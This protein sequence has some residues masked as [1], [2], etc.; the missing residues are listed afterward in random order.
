MLYTEG[1]AEGTP[2]HTRPPEGGAPLVLY[3]GNCAFCSAQAERLGRL[4]GGR[5]VLRPLQQEG[6]LETFPGLS[7]DEAM[8]EMK[9]IDGCG[10]V[11]GGAE[12]VV[13]ALELGSSGLGLLARA[14]YLP[15]LRPLTDRLYTW[16]AKNRYRLFGRGET[17]EGACPL[18]KRDVEDRAG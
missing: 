3:D 14:Y 9:L 1:M 7:R 15:G 2:L 8:R 18:A 16:V 4:A 10:R 11:Y 17:C 5:V 12:A 13:R 6:L